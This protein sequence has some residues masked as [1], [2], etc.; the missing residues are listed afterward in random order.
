MDILPIKFFHPSWCPCV[1]QYETGW[2]CFVLLCLVYFVFALFRLCL[3]GLV[4]VCFVLF[5]FELIIGLHPNCRKPGFG[6]RLRAPGGP[7]AQQLDP[8]RSL[9]R[10]MVKGAI[11]S[12]RQVSGQ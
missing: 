6:R 3:F 4:C 2:C 12:V 10:W 1:L 5:V 7:C 11:D 8:I 9:K